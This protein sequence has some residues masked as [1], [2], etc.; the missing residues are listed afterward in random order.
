MNLQARAAVFHGPDKPFELCTLPVR[1]PRTTEVLVR[2]SCC[3]I[4]GS[5]LHTFLGRRPAAASSVLGHEIMGRIVAF[6][7]DAPRLDLCGQP[8]AVGDRITWTSGASCGSCFFCEHD[9]PQKC[10]RLFKY[11]HELL[12]PDHPLSGGL[13]EFCL[14]A[15]G[16]GIVVL[17]PSLP[18]VVACPVNCAVAAVA[19]ALRFAGGCQGQTVLIQGAGMLGKV[20]CAMARAGG[21]QTII[22]CDVDPRRFSEAVH[23]GA[24]HALAAEPAQVA[25]CIQH[26][27]SG[28]GVDLAIELSGA[29]AAFELGLERVRIGGH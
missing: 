7:P 20:A 21:A 8:L 12:R 16:T 11:G 10:E 2:V 26:A 13:A 3:T 25:E 15:P 19:A 9:L 6:G 27:T 28:R 22:C 5:D 18:D 23:F 14:L 1:E 17:P 24:D 29:A 4:C